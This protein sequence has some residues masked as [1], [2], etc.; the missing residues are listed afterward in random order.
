ML[1][2]FRAD[3]HIHSCLSPC[4]DVEMSPL[5]IMRKAAAEGLDLIAVCDH[6]SAANSAAVE[7][8]AR[9]H[10]ITALAGIEISSLEEVH[11]LGLFASSEEALEVQAVLAG[12]LPTGSN[13]PERLGLQVLADERDNVLGFDARLLAASVDL[14]VEAVVDLIHSRRGLAVASHVDREGFGIIG[15]LGFIPPGLPLD[16]LEFSARARRGDAERRFGVYGNLPW[17]TSSDAHVLDEIGRVRTEFILDAPDLDEI[18][19]ALAGDEGRRVRAF[20]GPDGK[21]RE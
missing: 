6:N 13:D 14:P 20:L 3:L 21:E 4:A 11:I 18:R 2:V 9:Q 19:L 7:R 12:H 1:R 5:R 16:A 8:A 10:G 17:L 15:Q